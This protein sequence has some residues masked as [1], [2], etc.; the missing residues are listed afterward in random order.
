MKDLMSEVNDLKKKVHS[1]KNQIPLKMPNSS[2]MKRQAGSLK[3]K[4][5]PVRNKEN[6]KLLTIKEKHSNQPNQN[7]DKNNNHNQIKLNKLNSFRFM[8]EKGIV[9]SKDFPKKNIANV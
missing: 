9:F 2:L 7:N 6:E 4:E 1:Y 3:F 5:L 8:E